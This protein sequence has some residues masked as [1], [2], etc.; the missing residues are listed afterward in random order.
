MS[1]AE[2]QTSGEGD[3]RRWSG[4]GVASVEAGMTTMGGEAAPG[5]ELDAMARL[6]EERGGKEDDVVVCDAGEG[7]EKA[8]ARG[9]DRDERSR[10]SVL[11]SGVGSQAACSVAG[12]V[13]PEGTTP[14]EM[15][16]KW[17]LSPCRI[18][19]LSNPGMERGRG[20]GER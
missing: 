20:G 19:L 8:E 2:R 12:V 16:E 9:T 5:A 15:K 1:A 10:C 4:E 13:L 14:S 3:L 18:D 7:S 11:S 17:D 6:E